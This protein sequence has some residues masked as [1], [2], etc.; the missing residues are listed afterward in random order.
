MLYLVENKIIHR[1]LALRNV[2]VAK[3]SEGKYFAKVKIILY[4][5]NSKVSDFGL[6][7]LSS[8]GEYRSESKTIAIKWGAIESIQYGTFTSSSDVWSFGICIW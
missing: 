7:R 4:H 2:L 6:S 1:D 5:N 3:Q 8:T